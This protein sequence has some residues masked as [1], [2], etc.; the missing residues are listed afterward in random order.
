MRMT[1]EEYP[2]VGNMF[3]WNLNFSVTWSE[4]DPPQPLHEQAAFSILNPD[5][6][7]RPSFNA[8]QAAI[9]DI[10]QEQEQEQASQ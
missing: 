3:L 7:P 9:A 1:Y 6:S 10:Q 8:V 5:W 2:W 4:T